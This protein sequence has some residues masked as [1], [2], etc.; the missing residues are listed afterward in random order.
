MRL[1]AEFDALLQL[2]HDWDSYGA[3]PIK[4]KPIEMAKRILEN[5][6]G[7]APRVVP[8]VSGG[9]CL[10]WSLPDHPKWGKD[11]GVEI[12]CEPNGWVT[13]LIAV[14]PSEKWQEKTVLLGDA[15]IQQ[16]LWIATNGIATDLYG[17]EGQ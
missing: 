9:V 10:E 6:T 5:W 1:D 17:S 2:P 7:P 16:A 8:M 13:I 15:L 11:S 4:L 14:G 3:L 12:A